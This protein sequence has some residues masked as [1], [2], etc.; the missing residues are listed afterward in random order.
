MPIIYGN[1]FK[2]LGLASGEVKE[3]RSSTADTALSVFERVAIALGFIA[4]SFIPVVGEAAAATI[5]AEEITTGIEAAELVT[6]VAE[7]VG[8]SATEV[9]S[10]TAN[11]LRLGQTVKGSVG[12]GLGEAFANLGVDFQEDT[13]DPV[14]E[15]LNFGLAFTPIRGIV[16]GRRAASIRLANRAEE[17]IARQKELLS[18]AETVEERIQ[19]E[20]RIRQLENIKLTRDP[21]I[22][23]ATLASEDVSL[24]KKEILNLVNN[25]EGQTL[26]INKVASDIRQKLLDNEIKLSKV[27]A[28]AIV[29]TTT[30]NIP[31]VVEG[32]TLSS[33][34]RSKRYNQIVNA[35]RWADPN[36]A[37]RKV[38]TKA[39]HFLTT[40]EPLL[41]IG[42][43]TIIGGKK[44]NIGL[45]KKF[46]KKL[47]KFWRKWGSKIYK[48][49]RV[50]MIPVVS[51]WIEGYRLIETP[52]PSE[53]IMIVIFKP[54]RNGRIPRPRVISPVTLET[55]LQFAEGVGYGGSVGSFYINRFAL[56]R[57]GSGDSLVSDLASVLGPVSL[58]EL[59]NILAGPAAFERVIRDFAKGD[60]M[61]QWVDNTIETSN[62]LWAH[63][64]GK[65]LAGRWGI[66]A[67]R[68]FQK[69]SKG[70][71]YLQGNFDF[72]YLID[73]VGVVTLDKAR[74]VQRKAGIQGRTKSITA[75]RQLSQYQ[76]TAKLMTFGYV[77]FDGASGFKKGNGLF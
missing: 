48:S 14:N 71:T 54:S 20:T 60:Y 75:K 28:R 70:H 34:S 68:G 42:D 63:K 73:E 77:K 49:S 44:I 11:T 31:S 25:A 64:L 18:V 40:D 16:K 12:L 5:G 59:R 47:S 56:A 27:E 19:I 37:A 26:K 53:Y 35:L 45:Y 4:L 58:G 55:A 22:F 8:A 17:A 74:S 57:N 33:I 30:K 72:R 7:E 65:V 51:K 10:A 9:A 38:W 62:R 66:A 29:R 67:A 61:Q 13:V 21:N 50:K 52:V 39:A 2:P 76:R 32:V 15:I 6:G 24:A 69:T 41:Q 23:S 36:L 43:R 46:G 1:G 3:K